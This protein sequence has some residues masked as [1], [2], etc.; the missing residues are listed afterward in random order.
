VADASVRPARPA[1]AVEIARIQLVTW[2]T[3][4]QQI[5]P[6]PV[7]DSLTPQQAAAAWSEAI[8][9]APTPRHRVLV[10]LEQ[11]WVVGFVALTP[12]EDAPAEENTAETIQLGPLLVEPRWS[13]RG[14][15]S[16][17]LAAAVDIARADGLRRAVAWLPEADDV[18]RTFFSSA[19]WA[20]DG[21][22]RALDTGAGELREVRIHTAIDN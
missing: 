12:P 5:L 3:G 15:G 16:R 14:H 11:D 6:Q 17:L 20:A 10:A 19:G 4:Y 1:D 7:L 8:S 13:R 2:Q 22:L 18:S 21:Y 9:S